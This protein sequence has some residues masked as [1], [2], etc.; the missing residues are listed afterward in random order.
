MNKKIEVHSETIE[1][2]PKRHDYNFFIWDTSISIY[3]F[4][5]IYEILVYFEFIRNI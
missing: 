1:K 4:P 2:T 3:I 5:Y